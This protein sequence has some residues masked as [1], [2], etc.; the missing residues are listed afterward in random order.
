M[1][2][3]KR[4]YWM[5]LKADFM[6]SDEAD[7]LMSR[8]D[9][10]KLMVLYQL[11]CLKTMNTGGRLT[12]TMGDMK[13]PLTG[14]KLAR[15]LKW[16]SPDFIQEGLTLFCRMGL[17]ASDEEGTYIVRHEDLVGSETDW[18]DKRRRQRKGQG[19]NVPTEKEKEQEKEIRDK[20]LEKE[21][22]RQ[23]SQGTGT[24][25]CAQGTDRINDVYR[26]YQTLC[27]SYPAV[28][29]SK[30]RSALIAK[31]LSDSGFAQIE[32]AFHAAERS[33]FLKGGGRRGF[34]ADF[35]WMM[36]K[37]H[38]QKLA[39]R[40]YDDRAAESALDAL[41]AIAAKGS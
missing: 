18:A 8:Q 40:V 41:S 35:D 38:L 3:G 31:R 33:T 34:Q 27:P 36:T 19:D 2:T 1:A 13:L 15:D 25:A 6:A 10:A 30:A 9:G 28:T 29:E 21:I 22:D 4:Y 12:V 7:F 16:F 5:K 26:L 23:P 24:D 32:Q 39:D 17:L 11:L 37:Q 20:S 14:D